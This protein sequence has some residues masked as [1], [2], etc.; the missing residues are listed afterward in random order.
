M[1]PPAKAG[2]LCGRSYMETPCATLEKGWSGEARVR[3]QGDVDFRNAHL[4][5]KAVHSAAQEDGDPLVVDLWNLT[6]ID[7]S[8]I[9]ALIGAARQAREQGRGLRIEGASPHVLHLLTAAGFARFFHSAEGQPVPPIGSNGHGQARVWQHTAFTIPARV[10]L[11]SHIRTRVSEMLES[12]APDEEL[13]DAVRLAV[14]EAASN[15][16][17]HGC[18]GDEQLK[19]RVQ[20]ATDGET[21]VVEISDP[22]PGFDPDQ[23]PSPEVGELREGGMGIY[24]MRLTMDE[25]TYS[26]DDGGTTV[27]LIKRLMA[28]GRGQGAGVS[29]GGASPHSDRAAG[30]PFLTPDP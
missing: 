8:G 18:R 24:F 7:S 30:A 20:S 4:V 9:S 26:F 22:G 15:A 3:L 1:A 23:V 25:V 21:L 16:V 11:V 12:M 5:K 10:T 17:R 6:F 28:G 2:D 13:L 14:G 27:R 19:V 29:G